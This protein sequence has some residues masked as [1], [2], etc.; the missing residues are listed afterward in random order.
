[1]QSPGLATGSQTLPQSAKSCTKHQLLC[2]FLLHKYTTNKIGQTTIIWISCPQFGNLIITLD[3]WALFS[4]LPN[5]WTCWTLLV[6][7]ML[8]FYWLKCSLPRLK[9]TTSCWSL[10]F[11]IGM[12]FLGLFNRLEPNWYQSSAFW[13]TWT[14]GEDECCKAKRLC[15]T[16]NTAFW[17]PRE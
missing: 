14:S 11:E 10:A 9:K 6:F 2:Y 8:H 13:E 12:H 7:L 16:I 17:K 4:L 15:S 3:I 5:A 1:M